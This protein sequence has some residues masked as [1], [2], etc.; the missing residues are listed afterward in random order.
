MSDSIAPQPQSQTEAKCARRREGE[1]RCSS[2]LDLTVEQ[3]FGGGKDLN[4]RAQTSRRE[5]VD[6]R[7]LRQTKLIL[8][9]VV[10]RADCAELRAESCFLECGRSYLQRELMTWDLRDQQSLQS[11][12]CRKV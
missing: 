2:R 11:G 7:K 8:I 4:F 1:H 5:S 9:V 12:V 10:L 3:I 6:G